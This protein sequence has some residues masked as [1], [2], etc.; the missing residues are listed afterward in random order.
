MKISSIFVVF[1]ENINFTI[2]IILNFR[3]AKAGELQARPEHKPYVDILETLVAR[4]RPLPVKLEPLSNFETQV[5]AGRAWR[6]R[7]A[8]VFLKKNTN[9]PLLDVVCP[10]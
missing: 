4:G 3:L 9:L 6:E 2:K 1:L 7:T 10:R 5:A 8:R